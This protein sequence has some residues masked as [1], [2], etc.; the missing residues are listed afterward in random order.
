MTEQTVLDRLREAFPSEYIGLNDSNTDHR[1][2]FGGQGAM[3]FVRTSNLNIARI[4][5]KWSRF[6]SAFPNQGSAVRE[7]IND[8]ALGV[9]PHV[10]RTKVECLFGPDSMDRLIEALSVNP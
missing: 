3:I 5:V 8:P 10:T 6:L 9:R 1:F 4:E 7:V 2:R